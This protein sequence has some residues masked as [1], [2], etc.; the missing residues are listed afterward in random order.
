[1]QYFFI[2]QVFFVVSIRNF[3]IRF[4]P[5]PI[6]DASQAL[7]ASPEKTEDALLKVEK[8]IHPVGSWNLHLGA[9]FKINY[10]VNIREFYPGICF[11]FF[12]FRLS[13]IYTGTTRRGSTYR[14]RLIDFSRA[15]LPP[16]HS[17]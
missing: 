14:S 11:T 12:L 5:I 17:R 7:K 16:P 4:M 6:I 3:T 10:N 1:M 8:T 13:S 15:S 9:L 2:K